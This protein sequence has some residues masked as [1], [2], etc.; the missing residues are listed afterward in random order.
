[1][2][3]LSLGEKLQ[4]FLPPHE[5]FQLD[6]QVEKIHNMEEGLAVIGVG[7]PR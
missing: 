5:P 1:M 3:N 6:V 4:R 2:D 7:L